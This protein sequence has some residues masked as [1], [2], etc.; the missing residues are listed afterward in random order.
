MRDRMRIAARTLRKQAGFSTVVILS[1]A[2]A[3][4]LNTTMYG[5]L[6][7]LVHPRVEMR[8]P[9]SIARIQFYG[10]MRKPPGWKAGDPWPQRVKPAQRDSLLRAG[11][12]VITDIAWSEI[13]NASATMT[14]G[15]RYAE[16][17]VFRVG[18]EYFRLMGPRLVEGRAFIA[19]DFDAVSAPVVLAE[20]WAKRLVPPGASAIGAKVVIDKETYTVVGVLSHYSRF[21]NDFT[22][23]VYRLGRETSGQYRRIVRFRP[24]TS[25]EELQRELDVVGARI[26]VLAGDNPRDDAFRVALPNKAEVALRTFDYALMMAVAAVLL[27][28][29]ANV[30]NMQ[31][32]R[33]ITRARELAV[34][35]ALGATRARIIGHL[36]AES[37]LLA[38]AG[39]VLG[40][41][42][43]F[44][45][46]AL[47]RASIPDSVG[48]YI[49][50]PRMSWRVLGFA[51]TATIGC[52]L[53]VG[54]A[55]AIKVSRVDP[56]D[57]LK[58]GAGTGASRK[59]RRGYGY[60]VMAEIGLTLGLLSGAA[61]M[62]RGALFV[63]TA[64][65]G[66]DP[67][68][69]ATGYA[70]LH[71]SAEQ[72]APQADLL[73]SVVERLRGIRG[74]AEAEAD[75]S[76]SFENGGLSLADSSGLRMIEVMGY[77][78]R[79]VSPSYLRTFKRPIIMGRDFREGERDQPAI[80]VD[81]YTARKL[82]PNANPVGTLVKLGDARSTRPFVRLV[83]V[84]GQND[85]HGK[86]KPINFRDVGV[87]I[88]SIYYLPGT[89]DSVGSSKFGAVAEVTVRTPGNPATLLPAMRAAGVVH[90]LTMDD[91]LGITV[92]R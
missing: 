44:I 83:G 1:L 90:A 60:L 78:Y 5:V 43:T 25:R 36:L 8:D 64:W 12:P 63:Q 70:A 91:Y 85:E 51:I 26:A 55:P 23:A 24:G 88:G 19:S 14:V 27:V 28:A 18:L 80:I 81:E 39:L 61:V 3:I 31:L 57:L 56:N 76:G 52:I 29:C 72:R 7:A 54:V 15:D 6:D 73:A 37:S 82:W 49:V 59:H 33:G 46:S 20:P 13:V 86:P 4:A 47:L 42:L 87:T 21:P 48:S 32:A 89:A 22:P 84:V 40:L 17:R 65:F 75:M 34:R 53:L 10:D 92:P 66:Y 45:G 38:G 35:T 58:S 67:M 11:A 68:H 9:E 30:A 62:I 69:L 16:G 50:E 74:V 41:V 79:I 2:L 77:S 71:L